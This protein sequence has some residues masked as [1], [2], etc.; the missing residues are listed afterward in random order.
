MTT[1]ERT[2]ATDLLDDLLSG[3]LTYEKVL[4]AWIHCD[5]PCIDLTPDDWAC[6]F[7]EVEAPDLP[8]QGD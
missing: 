8:F 6:L 7:C 1:I 3:T 2:R 5:V 4:E